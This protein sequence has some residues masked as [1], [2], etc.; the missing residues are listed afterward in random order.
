MGPA[1]TN[2]PPVK[3]ACLERRIAI[4]AS[5]TILVI[6]P[7]SS[8]PITAQ[9]RDA[10]SAVDSD[11]A[12]ITSTDGPPAIESADDI[13]AAVAPMVELVEDHEAG[14]YVIACFADPGL[15]YV[16]DIAAAP[17][18][19]I[20]ESAIRSAM[21]HGTNIGIIASSAESVVRHTRYWQ[22]LGLADRIVAEAPLGLGVLELNTPDAVTAALAAGRELLDSGADVIVLGCTGMTHMEAQLREEFGVPVI[23]PCR[24][25]VEIARRALTDGSE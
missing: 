2:P 16:R 20:A 10:V 21:E 19:G 6:N 9:I 12:V 24:A 25:A 17:A 7:N 18:Y 11:V 8:E 22:K 1:S 15:D 23:D 13:S 5:Q 3:S 14:A 4:P